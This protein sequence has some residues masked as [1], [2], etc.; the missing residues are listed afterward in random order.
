M[1]GEAALRDTELTLGRH[2]AALAPV[3]VLLQYEVVMLEVTKAARD[4]I[5]EEARRR[6]DQAVALFLP[7]GAHHLREIFADWREEEPLRLDPGFVALSL[8]LPVPVTLYAESRIVPVLRARHHL[9]DV[10]TEF[11]HFRSLTVREP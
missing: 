8:G 3:A 9:L 1:R 4:F 2:P 5:A 11:G 10:R 6:R 7:W